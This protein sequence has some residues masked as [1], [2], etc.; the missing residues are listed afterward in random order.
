MK[1]LL[2]FLLIIGSH[3]YALEFKDCTN[4]H[5]NCFLEENEP[6]KPYILRANTKKTA[7]FI[8]GLS[9]SPYFTKDL[10]EVLNQNGYNVYSV[11][12]SG[13]GASYKDLLKVKAEDWIEDVA[14]TIQLA[15]N[16]TGADQ[17]V[18]VGFSLGGVLATTFAE[19]LRWKNQ[20]S[21]IVLLAP[22]F[23]IKKNIRGK[24]M[25]AMGATEIMAWDRPGKSLVKYNQMYLH[26]VCELI[27]LAEIAKENIKSINVPVYMV[28]TDGDT[29]INTEVALEKFNEIQG[30]KKLFHIRNKSISHTDINFKH[31]HLENKTNTEFDEMARQI[32]QFLR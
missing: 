4:L 9:D 1:S 24:L 14:Q 25:C 30:A 20:V 2:A 10:A 7:V 28:V 32:V 29:T 19:D 15:L 16:E 13:H 18:L 26:P 21:K 11:L 31:D 5:A 12:L 3:A 27:R 23:Q 6:Q 8:H 17:V 22:A